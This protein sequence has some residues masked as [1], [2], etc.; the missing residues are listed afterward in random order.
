V[1]PQRVSSTANFLHHSPGAQPIDSV[2]GAPSRM[3]RSHVG[4]LSTC[5]TP[6]ASH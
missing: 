2:T 4:V 3:H 6:A 5:P 1:A